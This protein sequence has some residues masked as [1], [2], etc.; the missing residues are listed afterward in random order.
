MSS[1]T[2]SPIANKIPFSLEKHNDIRVDNYFWLNKR[3]APEVLQYLEEE[4]AYYEREMSHTKGFE[5]ALFEEMKARIK[6]DDESV[7]Y[8]YN[9]Y[10]YITK[11]ETG[12]N[13]PIYYRRKELLS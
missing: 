12:K 13:Y 6:E 9:G 5:D 7:P 10:W 1:K 11:F 2:V 3:D 4:N 8:K